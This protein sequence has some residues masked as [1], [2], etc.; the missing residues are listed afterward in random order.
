MGVVY[1][2]HHTFMD[3][4]VA[5][6][7]LLP[8]V[9]DGNDAV[10]RFM[11][12]A[13]HAA[14]IPGENVC[15]ILDVGLL[16]SGFPYMAME[17]LQGWSLD[18]ILAQRR[19]VQPVEAARWVL[20]AL[21]AVA[22]AHARGI[23]HRDLKPSNLFLAT[24]DDGRSI[25]KVLDFGISK[26]SDSAAH[27]ITSTRGMLG[28]PAY[29]APEHLRNPKGLDPRADLWS[30]GVVLYELVSG[31]APFD[32]S[33]LGELFVA[34]L[35]GEPEPLQRRRPDAPPGFCAVVHRCLTKRL[36]VRFQNAAELA[37]A[38][39]PFAGPEGP[40]LADRVVKALVT[41]AGPRMTGSAEVSGSF[42]LPLAAPAPDPSVP[43]PPPIA[44]TTGGSPWAQ[45]TDT[46]R[47][48]RS[49]A[50]LAAIAA[51][52]CA[53][54]IVVVV[55]L[56]V[57]RKPETVAPASS[58]VP[59][60]VAAMPSSPPA[61]DTQPIAP[62]ASTVADPAPPPP[63]ASSPPTNGAKLPAAAPFASTRRAPARPGKPSGGLSTSR[64]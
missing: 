19:T 42:Q 18:T 6:K 27:N 31:A 41:N 1:A 38:L 33:S 12:E 23:V 26:S 53:A 43:T 36:D 50:V 57:R 20:E 35:E 40:A 15:R 51:T 9:L 22:H 32:A 16:E 44:G 59:V 52:A 34:I 54:F 47:K 48:G 7:L 5:L 62:L 8:E 4:R 39:A 17:Y 2:A 37:A 61:S 46:S 28:S 13:R 11:T 45:S 55:A 60:T 21:V 63:Q 58:G 30:L 56:A 3:Q 14:K 24:A 49:V 64:D 29:V 25:V 10:T